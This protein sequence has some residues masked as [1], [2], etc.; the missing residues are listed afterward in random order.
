MGKYNSKI[1]AY[2]HKAAP[3]AQPILVHLRELVHEACPDVEESVKWSMPFFD[4][5][6][7]LCNMAAF[8]Q[9]AVFGFWKGKLL[10]DPKNYLQ[11]RSTEGGT[12]MGHLGKITSLKDLPPNKVIVA[13]IKQAAKLNEDGIK[14]EPKP[15]TE[16]KE[17]IVPAYFKTALKT[18]K[19]AQAV[20]V[21][22]SYSNKKEYVEWVTEAKTDATREKRLE[23]AVAWMAE[24]KV[25]NWKY[26]KK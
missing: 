19:K 18:N 9:H 16:K 25:R 17:L 6:G 4:Y 13:F 8:K 21:A 14:L 5:Q 12:A 23:T 10:H 3:F 15:K 22:F 24:G 7:P 2:I 11:E 20:F 26:L 1:D